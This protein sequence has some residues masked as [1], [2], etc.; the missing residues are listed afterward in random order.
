MN[1]AT[2]HTPNP[3]ETSSGG[4]KITHTNTAMHTTTI[5]HRSNHRAGRT[6]ACTGRLARISSRVAFFRNR[7][8]FASITCSSSSS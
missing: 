5:S 7:V 8:G 4:R 6:R 3:A 1:D 2:R